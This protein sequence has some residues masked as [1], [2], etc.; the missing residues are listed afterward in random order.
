VKLPFLITLLLLTSLLPSCFKQEP[1]DISEPLSVQEVTRLN[2]C[3]DTNFVKGLLSHRN[4]LNL[5]VCTNWNIRFPHMY[6]SLRKIDPIAWNH[7]LDPVNKNF[8][9]DKVRRDRVFSD[10]RKLDSENGLDDLGRVMTALVETNFYDAMSV[11]FICSEDRGNSRCV[12]RKN[13]VPDKESVKEMLKFV[14]LKPQ[15]F[16]DAALLIRH[17]TKAIGKDKELFRDQVNQ[18][19]H[20]DVFVTMRLNLISKLAEKII[21]GISEK[22]RDFVDRLLTTKGPGT[23]DPWIHYWLNRDE[24]TQ[25]SFSGLLRYSIDQNPSFI[26]DVKVVRQGFKEGLACQNYSTENRI[27]LKLKTHVT[28]FLNKIHTGGKKEFYEFALQNINDATLAKPFCPM[29]S[30]FA[31]PI[32]FLEFDTIVKEEHAINFSKI[33]NDFSE[34]VSDD[35]RYVVLKFLL[36]LSMEEAR[37]NDVSSEEYII[38]MMTDP[39]FEHLNELNKFMIRLAPRFFEVVYGIGRRFHQNGFKSLANLNSELITNKENASKILGWAESWRFFTREEHNFLFNY[40]DAH[41][42]E[43][44]N[45]ILLFNFYAKMLDE[46]SEVGPKI[47]DAWASNEVLLEKTFQSI[48]NLS[49]N[50]SGADTLNDFKKFFSRDHIIKVMQIVTVGPEIKSKAIARLEDIYSQKYVL[51]SSHESYNLIIDEDIEEEVGKII[52][53]LK[54]MGSK[55]NDFYKLVLSLP[56]DCRSLRSD[57]FTLKVFNWS[58]AIANNYAEFN[59]SKFSSNDKKL[60]GNENLFDRFGL[61]SPGMLNTG[62]AYT[63]IIDKTLGPAGLNPDGKGGVSYL[64]NSLYQHLYQLKGGGEG[65]QP[66]LNNLVKFAGVVLAEDEYAQRAF[67]NRLLHELSEEENFNQIEPFLNLSHHIFGDY[68][69]WYGDYPAYQADLNRNLGVED[70]SY[71][72]ENFLNQNL[73]TEECP[74]N[75]KIKFVVKVLLKFLKKRNDVGTKTAIGQFMQAFI[76]GSGIMIPVLEKDKKTGKKIKKEVLKRLS[77]KEAIKMHYDFTNKSLPINQQVLEYQHIRK[78]VPYYLPTEF[79]MTVPISPFIGSRTESKEKMT[80]MER[81]EIVIRDIRFDMGYLGAH[82]LNATSKGHDYDE[83]LK[84]KLALFEKCVPLKFCGKFL[85]KTEKRLGSNAVMTFPG[86]M[87]ANTGPGF[88]YAPFMKALLG[89]LVRSSER[90]SRKSSLVKIKMF[91]KDLQIPWVQTKK[92]LRNHNVHILARIAQLSALSNIGRFIQD[93]FGRTAGEF[94]EFFNG[95]EL[96][97]IDQALLRGFPVDKSEAVLIDVISNLVDVENTDGK[98]FLDLMIDW[99]NGLEYQELKLVENTI[100]QLLVISSYLGT[101]EF[102]FKK[103]T[104]NAQELAERYKDNNLFH[105]VNSLSSIIKVWPEV[106][107]AFDRKNVKMIKVVKTLNN[108]LFF[109]KRNLL[110]EKTAESGVYYRFLNEVFLILNKGLLQENSL[111]QKGIDFVARVMGDSLNSEQAIQGI[112]DFYD[113]LSKLHDTGSLIEIQKNSK[114]LLLSEETSGES[115]RNYLNFASEP[116][117]CVAG[118]THCI[119]NYH[120]DEPSILLQYVASPSSSLKG[121]NFQL[122][123]DTLLVDERKKLI[124]LVENLTPY[125]TIEKSPLKIPLSY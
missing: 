32:T 36:H 99:L 49:V 91:G 86:L 100:G 47:S 52:N 17:I 118:G 125:V 5:F 124:E 121:S 83:T 80:T 45:Y 26:K 16:T 98:I 102:L 76:P 37:E 123:T 96:D 85:N 21:A 43:K 120:Y 97:L 9:D 10:L 92:Q 95:R 74:S 109:F 61:V 107:K 14:S 58:N 93:R 13:P 103:E 29:L 51:R 55:D 4:T 64:I 84:S 30:R 117:R 90:K 62:T 56:K 63:K 105:M 34:F 89:S 48:K 38:E 19:F 68:L 70:K 28:E 72:C 46:L 71:S 25:A 22:D 20:E 67:R 82:Y 2:A 11:L 77:L 1:D 60:V 8:F 75:R 88:R 112:S 24:M 81:I 66:E 12:D 53:C 114:K 44:T 65:F 57:E 35:N 104:T 3:K 106:E 33:I 79:N 39:I 73:G 41:L 23:E 115:T 7:A 18:Y 27:N 110:K 119:R 113:Y 108:L 94:K 15:V 69:K 122:M 40:I 59:K 54:E 31:K 42:A 116:L 6:T 87:D 78:E 101:P 50:L 111:D